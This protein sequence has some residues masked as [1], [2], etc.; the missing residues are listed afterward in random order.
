M[1]SDAW[2]ERYA[3]GGLLWGLAPNRFVAAETEALPP[4]RALDLACGEGRNAIWLAERGW[5][6]R[7]IDYSEVAID[8]ARQLAGNRRV[9]VALEVGNV[10]EVELEPACYDLVLVAYVQLAPV[11]RMRLLDRAVEAVSPGG[12]LLL[13]GHHAR[14][15]AE[16]TGGPSDP[17][18]LWD[19][20]EVV[21]SIES[22]GLDVGKAE[23]VLREVDGADRPAIDLL[24]VAMKPEHG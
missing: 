21:S 19:T 9:D 11:E 13:V 7:A 6:V 4:G 20:G 3:T 1:N 18:R 8:R 16:G 22:A 23:E 14:N 12:A 15:H 2:N 17:S 10:L 24:V 5:R